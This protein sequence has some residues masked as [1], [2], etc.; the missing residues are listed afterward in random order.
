MEGLIPLHIRLSLIDL[1]L[2]RVARV[3]LRLSVVLKVEPAALKRPDSPPTRCAKESWAN[4]V[5]PMPAAI[6]LLPTVMA[7]PRHL[8]VLTSRQMP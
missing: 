4:Q 3:W 7:R 8:T 5:A 1:L 6:S 2:S